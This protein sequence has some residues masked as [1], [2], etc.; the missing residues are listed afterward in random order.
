MRGPG[1]GALG[2]YDPVVLRLKTVPRRHGDGVAFDILAA[3][4]TNVGM[5]EILC[6]FEQPV[7]LAIVCLGADAYG[8]M[9]LIMCS[10]L[11][12]AMY[13]PGRFTPPSTGW[14][15][16]GLFAQDWRKVRP[17]EEADHSATTRSRPKAYVPS[18]M[19]TRR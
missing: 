12:S 15:I 8:R 17:S 11:S 13:Q 10:S 9:I 16:A 18:T 6:S 4:P 7:L 2:I 3:M 19:P 14:K 1:E 5:A